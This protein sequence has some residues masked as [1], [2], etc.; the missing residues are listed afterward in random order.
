MAAA[1][2]GCRLYP[3]GKNGEFHTA[4]SA[5][6]MFRYPI[7]VEIG[8]VVERGEFVFVDLLTP[9]DLLKY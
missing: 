2:L 7:A 3:C 1:R 4:V 5:G 9:S 8:P 6:P